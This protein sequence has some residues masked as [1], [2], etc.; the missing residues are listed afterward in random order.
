MGAGKTVLGKARFEEM[1]WNL[2]GITIKHY[3]SDNGVYDAATFCDHCHEHGQMQSF[4]GVGAKHQ[5]AIAK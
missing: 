5:N 2:G 3:L 1:M 4:W